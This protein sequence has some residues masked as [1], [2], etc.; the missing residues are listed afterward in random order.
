MT[1]RQFGLACKEF[2]W[3][4][5]FIFCYYFTLIYSNSSSY[6]KGDL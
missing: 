5:H 4:V 2:A 6:V 3:R 1:L